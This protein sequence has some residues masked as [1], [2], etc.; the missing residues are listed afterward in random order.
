[1]DQKVTMQPELPIINWILSDTPNHKVEHGQQHSIISRSDQAHTGPKGTSYVKKWPKLSLLQLH[2]LLSQC[3]PMAS[4]RVPYNLLTEEEKTQAWFIDSSEQYAA[5]THKW[6]DVVLQPLSGRVL[7]G[8]GEGKPP[9]R[10]NFDKYTR[11]FILLR[12]R[13]GQMCNYIQIHGL[14]P[15]FG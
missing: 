12:R 3:A 13:N 1:M 14:C 2:C 15:R 10:Q 6:T 9:S 11:L 7:K 8:S 4:W 5:T